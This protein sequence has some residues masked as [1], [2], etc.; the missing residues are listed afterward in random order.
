MNGNAG[1]ELTKKGKRVLCPCYLADWLR[2]K[3][4]R[5][6]IPI[7]AAVTVAGGYLFLAGWPA[8]KFDRMSN[9]RAAVAVAR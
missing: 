4:R 9:R 6:R 3:I 5:L 7:I 8:I 1:R 2:F